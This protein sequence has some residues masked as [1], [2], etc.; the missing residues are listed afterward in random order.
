[1]RTNKN[2]EGKDVNEG[3]TNT[4]VIVETLG[5]KVDEA[6]DSVGLQVE[7]GLQVV[8]SQHSIS[9]LEDGEIDAVVHNSIQRMWSSMIAFG[10]SLTLTF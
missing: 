1:M 4:E 2:G 7:E 6:N 5:D 3:T 9:A 10:T 8:T